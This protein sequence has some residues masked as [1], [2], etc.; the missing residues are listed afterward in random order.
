MKIPPSSSPNYG[1]PPLLFQGENRIEPVIVENEKDPPF[2]TFIKTMPAAVAVL[3]K[4]LNYIITSDRWTE[5]TNLNIQAIKGKCIYEVVPDLPPRWRLIHQRA[6]KGEHLKSEDDIFKRQDGTIEWWRW[7]V[8]PWYT[9]HNTVGGIILFVEHITERKKMETKMKEMIAALN[10]SNADLQSFARICAH[11]LNE[12]LRTIANYSRMMEEEFKEELSSNAKKY[13]HNISKSITHMKT[14]I[15]GILAYSQFEAAGLQKRRFS[16]QHIINDVMI[17]LEEKIKD[18]KAFIYAENLPFVYG[19]VRLIGRVFQN[20]MSNALKFNKSDMPIIY[21]VA[22]EQKACWKFSV[23][24]NG[25]G[26]DKKHHKKIFGLFERLHHSS[27]YKGTGIGL[28]VSKKIIEA[29]GGKM[30][31]ESALHKGSK[32]FFTLPK[33]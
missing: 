8:L 18:K 6:L 20:L 1:S 19:D 14:M 33:G 30:W 17:V 23:E 21:V 13:L 27:E 7:E 9:P 25:I 2:K 29:H 22:K 4:G 28:S 32:F 11:D 5:E 16:A 3:D 24:D 10:R 31:V 15:D 12:P 26:I